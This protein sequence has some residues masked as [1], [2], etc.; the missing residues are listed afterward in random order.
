MVPVP[1]TW[2]D[3]ASKVGNAFG[4]GHI[5]TVV[6]DFAIVISG[7]L[8]FVMVLTMVFGTGFALIYFLW[9]YLLSLGGAAVRVAPVLGVLSRSRRGQRGRRR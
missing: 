8:A 9:P 7:A 3:F 4:G 1:M 2:F 5:M 6:N